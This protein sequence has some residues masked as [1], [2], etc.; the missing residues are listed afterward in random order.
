MAER[1]DAVVVGAG[2]NGLAA[3]ITLARTGWRVLVLEAAASAGGAARSE[4]LTLPGYVH[5]VGAAI[6]PLALA[7]PFMRSLPL[8]R[9]GVTWVQSPAALAHPLGQGAAVL[10]QSF[11][12]TGATLGRDAAAYH[13]LMAPLV[14]DWQRLMTT[15]LGPLQ[16]PRH[17]LALGRFLL[18]AVW[19]ARALAERL[20]QE[21]PAR[22]LI[23][24]LAGHAIVPLEQSP[25]AAV[26]LVLG[27]LGHAVGWPLVRGGTQCL[28]DGMVAYLTALGGAVVT[29]QPVTTL[30]SLPPA[31]AVLC[32][33]TPRQLLALA[34][35]RLPA[36]YRARLG[37]FR[38]G[39]GVFKLDWALRAPIPWRDAACARAATVHIGGTLAEIADAERR[40]WAGT[41]PERPNVILVQP[42]L[43]DPSRAPAGRHTAWA[44]C[45]VPHGATVDM[46]AAIEAQIERV[47]PGFGQCVLARHALG[48][49]ALERFDA[50]LIGGDISGGVLDWRQLFT[51]PT[52]SLTPYVTP[53]PGLYLCSSSTPPGGGVHGMAGYWAA[54][55]A[56]RRQR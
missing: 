20:F 18:A 55:T 47:A 23:A 10:A 19:P 29:G 9:F 26:A 17:P 38:H 42:S 4:A 37:R 15:V 36:G 2:P 24:G 27:A 44:Y 7:S 14:H 3:A 33:V 11:A 34:G 6:H 21:E 12:A 31:R 41:T 51:R 48:P 1:Y 13:C 40:A 22:A 25:S 49:V 16:L 50:N 5:D 43:F 39:P 35:D 45:H 32:D 56:L 8:A 30:A 52:P 54:R 46:T 53:A 28:I